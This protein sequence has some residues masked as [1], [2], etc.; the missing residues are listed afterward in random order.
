MYSNKHN[1]KRKIPRSTRHTATLT[2]LYNNPHRRLPQAFTQTHKRKQEKKLQLPCCALTHSTTAPSSCLAPLEHVRLDNV[3]LSTT[4]TS[5][6][7]APLDNVHLSATCTSRQRAPLC[8]VH[9][10]ATC[11]SR[12][13][14]PLDNVRCLPSSLP[15]RLHTELY[16][17]FLHTSAP[18]HVLCHLRLALFSRVASAL[19][20]SGEDTLPL[21]R[22][23]LAS[24]TGR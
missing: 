11:T 24:E 18:Q 3:H 5:R 10:S 1:A 14:A 20:Q 4:G 23:F 12:H 15:L 8:N 9:L 16:E 2:Q 22:P 13:V 7:R 17:R 6:Q 19:R 21:P